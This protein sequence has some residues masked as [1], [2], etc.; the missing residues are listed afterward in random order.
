MFPLLLRHEVHGLKCTFHII[1]K[2]A[3]DAKN[4][5]ERGKNLKAST[6]RRTFS[7]V[8]YRMRNL[9]RTLYGPCDVPLPLLS[10]RVQAVQPR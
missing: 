6:M 3:V 1:E 2:L 10:G 8:Q 4:A 9:C 7:C 5:L